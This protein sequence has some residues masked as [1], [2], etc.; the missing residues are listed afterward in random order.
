MI[1][2]TA[3]VRWLIRR[4]LENEVMPIEEATFEFPWS[5]EEFIK[6]LRNRNTIGMVCE[7]ND[8]VVGYMVYELFRNRISVINF[9][10]AEKHRRCGYGSA[11]IEKLVNKLLPDRRN[12]ITFEVRET[13]LDMQ[14]FLRAQGF[15]AVSV[16]KDH[17]ED[18]P[19]D[20]Y[21]FQ[22]RCGLVGY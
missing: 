21:L 19:E 13:N 20:A 4:D 2:R 18:S 7:I 1:T 3:Q 12:K 17:Y 8:E 9:A 6:E 22:F 14:K 10:V 5:K 11:M 16:L 15:F